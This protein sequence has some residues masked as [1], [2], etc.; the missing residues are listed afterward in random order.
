MMIQGKYWNVFSLNIKM[1]LFSLTLVFFI[2]SGVA[3]ETK[4]APIINIEQTKHVFPA[5]FEGEDLLH[6]FIVKNLG[7]TDLVIKKVTHS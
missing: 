5:V 1:L 7:T 2:Y 3:A 4:P 6:T